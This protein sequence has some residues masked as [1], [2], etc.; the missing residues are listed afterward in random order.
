MRRNIEVTVN[1]E[2]GLPYR[3]PLLSDRVRM[4]K[5]FLLLEHTGGVGSIAN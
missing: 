2:R 1:F 5:L 4:L 3:I